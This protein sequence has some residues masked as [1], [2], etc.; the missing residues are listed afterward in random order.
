MTILERISDAIDEHRQRTGINPARVVV[1]PD[2]LQRLLDESG[3]YVVAPVD[4]DT[5]SAVQGVPIK[6]IEEPGEFVGVVTE[7]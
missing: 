3:P 7:T 5:P 6:T 1:S 4:P 2:A